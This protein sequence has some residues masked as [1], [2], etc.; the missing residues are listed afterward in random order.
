MISQGPR[1][2]YGWRFGSAETS[3][4]SWRE[5]GNQAPCVPFSSSLI[6]DMRFTARVNRL[7]SLC[8]PIMSSLPTAVSFR[9]QPANVWVHS[10]TTFLA[11]GQSGWKPGQTRVESNWFG[12]E[13]VAIADSLLP[14]YA[15]HNGRIKG[16]RTRDGMAGTGHR[17]HDAT[18]LHLA[19][20]ERG[21]ESAAPFSVC[22]I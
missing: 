19:L 8:C 9:S 14:S 7:V 5:G 4:R 15:L 22:H 10:P 21:E 3:T 6:P 13:P 20:F 18:V 16:T 1:S 12:R 17:V 2:D 11:T